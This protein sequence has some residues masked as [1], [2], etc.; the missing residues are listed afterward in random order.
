LRAREIDFAAKNNPFAGLIMPYQIYS[1]SISNYCP[2][3]NKISSDGILQHSS[4]SELVLSFS[5]IAEFH[6][7]REMIG[8]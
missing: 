2:H 6:S 4:G 7:L 8:R 5:P 3:F 1:Q